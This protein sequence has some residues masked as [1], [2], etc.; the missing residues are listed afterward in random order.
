M[1]STSPTVRARRRR[2]CPAPPAH[3]QHR[4]AGLGRRL[5][6][7]LHHQ[8]GLVVVGHLEGPGAAGGAHVPDDPREAE[9]PRRAPVD[10]EAR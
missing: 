5:G 4:G 10:V 1:S 8:L 6:H 7:P 9:G 2:L 3:P